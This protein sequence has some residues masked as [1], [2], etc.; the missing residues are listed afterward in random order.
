MSKLLFALLVWTLPFGALAGGASSGTG[1]VS[2][3]G[4]GGGGGSIAAPT[5]HERAWA[6]ALEN[7]T[8]RSLVEDA[9]LKAVLRVGLAGGSAG[10]FD[11]LGVAVQ[12]GKEGEAATAIFMAMKREIQRSYRVSEQGIGWLEVT[13]MISP[14]LEIFVQSQIPGVGPLLD[15]AKIATAF[16]TA[17]TYHR[18]FD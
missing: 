15:T 1:A 16:A 17:Y 7:R 8:F 5:P 18:F 3:G 4:G 9:A 10:A 6:L 2:G 11:V 12:R 14:L 13:R